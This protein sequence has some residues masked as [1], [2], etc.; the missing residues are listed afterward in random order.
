VIALLSLKCRSS[1]LRAGVEG[2]EKAS[3]HK[4]ISLSTDLMLQS[5]RGFQS[6]SYQAQTSI[7]V[8]VIEFESS[9]LGPLEPAIHLQS[10]EQW[11]Q[12]M[13]LCPGNK[14]K[15]QVPVPNDRSTAK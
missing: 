7:A 4:Q 11:R 13:S 15:M 3:R 2:K 5:W 6:S 8:S 12:T 10:Q 9:N 1:S 14:K